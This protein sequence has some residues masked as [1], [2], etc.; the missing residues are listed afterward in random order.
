MGKSFRG[1]WQSPECSRAELWL[2]R[3]L[4]LFAHLLPL[5][6]IQCDLGTPQEH[7]ELCSTLQLCVSMLDEGCQK[8]KRAEGCNPTAEVFPEVTVK[9]TVGDSALYPALSD[10]TLLSLQVKR[11][12]LTASLSD[13]HIWVWQS[14]CFLSGFYFIASNKNSSS[15]SHGCIGFAELIVV[16]SCF[17][18]QS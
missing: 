12:F 14:S 18:P 8:G 1:Q 13:S 15:F 9:V 11:W 17:C 16:K 3:K 2:P 7:S 4:P 10:K 5:Q 6:A